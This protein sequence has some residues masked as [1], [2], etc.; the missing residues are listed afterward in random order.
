MMEV[1]AGLRHHDITNRTSHFICYTLKRK[2][3]KTIK[4][5][6]WGSRTDGNNQ[7]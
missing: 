1:A 6:D 4:E 2:G 3:M 7:Q 5:T